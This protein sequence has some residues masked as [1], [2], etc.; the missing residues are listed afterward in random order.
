MLT[1]AKIV[2]TSWFRHVHSQLSGSCSR[3]IT[4][5][6]VGAGTFAR[7]AHVPSLQD[8]TDCFE[9]VAVWSRSQQ[10]AEALAAEYRVPLSFHGEDRPQSSGGWPVTGDAHASRDVDWLRRAR[11]RLP[12]T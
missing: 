9:L 10:S 7:K 12:M 6:L 2:A 5:A 4:V 8:A 3:P 1:V 11:A